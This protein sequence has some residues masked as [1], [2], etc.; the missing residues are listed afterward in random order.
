MAKK[1]SEIP[2]H[3]ADVA[4]PE[5]PPPL[6]EAEAADVPLVS[7]ADLP[8]EPPLPVITK[9]VPEPKAAP[10]VWRVTEERLVAVNGNHHTFVQKGA[11]Y[12]ARVCGP[13]LIA[14]FKAQKVPMEP[15]E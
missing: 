3:V 11:I 7:E 14:S 12:D 13:E 5:M 8:P 10:C 2:E 1:K 15:V 9:P 6:P 4:A